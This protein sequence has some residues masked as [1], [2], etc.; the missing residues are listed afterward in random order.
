M[1]SP[2]RRPLPAHLPK[3]RGQQAR[4]ELNVLRLDEDGNSL[5]DED[6]DPNVCHCFPNTSSLHI[7]SMLY[8]HINCPH[9]NTKHI[10][11]AQAQVFAY[12]WTAATN[13]RRQTVGGGGRKP[14]SPAADSLVSDKLSLIEEEPRTPFVIKTAPPF[15]NPSVFME[16]KG[17]PPFTA[18]AY[19]RWESHG[20]KDVPRAQSVPSLTGYNQPRTPRQYEDPNPNISTPYVTNYNRR[21]VSIRDRQFDG[22]YIDPKDGQVYKFRVKYGKKEIEADRKQDDTIREEPEECN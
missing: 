6:F 14:R 21:P 10:Q 13:K 4:I 20:G 16:S 11:P 5:Y 22:R 19:S 9:H 8:D 2:M 1:A 18:P 17:E 3:Q 7:P 15:A 12:P